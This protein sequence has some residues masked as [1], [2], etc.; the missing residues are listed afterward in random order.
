MEPWH[1]FALLR[2]RLPFVASLAIGCRSASMNTPNVGLCSFT[3]TRQM[4]RPFRK[5]GVDA[6]NVPFIGDFVALNVTA[7][8]SE[9]ENGQFTQ[10]LTLALNAAQ[11]S[12]SCGH[13]RF[14][15]GEAHLFSGEP[16]AAYQHYRAARSLFSCAA[17]ES[18]CREGG[19]RWAVG[20]ASVTAYMPS[21]LDKRLQMCEYMLQACTS[22]IAAEV[23]I[24]AISVHDKATLPFSVAMADAILHAFPCHIGTIRCK[25]ALLE[26]WRPTDP[27]ATATR[28]KLYHQLADLE[29]LRPEALVQIASVYHQVQLARE[30]LGQAPGNLADRVLEYATRA[31]EREPRNVEALRLKGQQ[32]RFKGDFEFAVQLCNE[33]F[34]G[35]IHRCRG[36]V[37]HFGGPAQARCEEAIA[38]EDLTA[39]NLL[40]AIGIT[41][42]ILARIPA[43]GINCFRKWMSYCFCDRASVY[44]SAATASPDQQQRH[45]LAKKGLRD[46]EYAVNIL[47][48]YAAGL[49]TMALC[50]DVLGR[51]DD[52]AH[53][54]KASWSAEPTARVKKEMESRRIFVEFP[55]RTNV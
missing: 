55:S 6:A 9:I 5:A 34:V 36:I 37:R 11:L 44:L 8:L 19:G 49:M 20:A 42:D 43:S 12:P 7:A 28:L 10:A 48:S 29:P 25:L 23:A 32:L 33:A 45:T 54:L 22:E 39:S 16:E 21:V 17:G 50:Y 47:P 46:A 26:R 15:L 51:S 14:V 18:C 3:G 38:P 53:F 13:S 31:L 40:K 1:D 52:A 30:A 2:P 35:V 27:A 4:S 41:E 24:R